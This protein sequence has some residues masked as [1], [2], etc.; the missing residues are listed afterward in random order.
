MSRPSLTSQLIS[1]S[2]GWAIMSKARTLCQ[3]QAILDWGFDIS[4][5]KIL[6]RV[7]ES[8][9]SNPYKV[10]VLFAPED[11]SGNVW[12][13][14]RCSC[15][16]VRDCVHAAAVALMAA[17][18]SE[19]GGSDFTAALA[20]QQAN[21][22][23]ESEGS[24]YP[25][26][27]A[28]WLNRLDASLAGTDA[29][30]ESEEN[31]I[32]MLGFDPRSNEN[33]LQVEPRVARRL[34]NGNFGSNRPH[35][36]RQLAGSQARFMLESDQA[37]AKL[38]TA[39]S[40]QDSQI[41]PGRPVPPSNDGEVLD[42]L[43]VRIVSTGRAYFGDKLDLPLKLGL[44]KDGRVEWV[45][46]EDSRQSPRVVLEQTSSAI[47]I[48]QSSSPWYLDTATGEVGPIRFAYG[49]E[50]FQ[51]L[52]AAPRLA[53][54][55][56]LL[57]HK[58]LSEKA[59]GLPLPQLDITEV[60]RSDQPIVR[61]NLKYE[62]FK[63]PR[64]V[65]DGSKE[66]AIDGDNTATLVFD[67][68]FDASKLAD[69][70]ESYR[71][72]NG[73][74]FI[75]SRR[76]FHFE[77]AVEAKLTDLS[78]KQF[79]SNK[80]PPTQSCWTA[81]IYG[82]ET[83]LKFVQESV[84]LL[85]EDGWQIEADQ[86]FQYQVVDVDSD[87]LVD[88]DE[89]SPF[90]F[91]LDLGIVVDHVRVPL[92][93]IITEAI[94]SSNAGMNLSVSSMDKLNVGGKFYA[95]LPDKRMVALPFERVKDMLSCLTELLD[96][97]N[98][99]EDGSLNISI[100]QVTALAAVNQSES[101][102][103]QGAQSVRSMAAE[104]SKF[105]ILRQ[106]NEPQSLHAVLRPYQ[107][108]G[109]GWL[110]F[111]STF[112]LG[113]ILADDMGLGK[114]VQTLAH[115]AREKEHGKLEGRPCLVVC[116][117]S[118]LPNWLAEIQRLTPSL[119]VVALHGAQRATRFDLVQSADI[120]LSTYPLLVRDGEFLSSIKWHAV[121]L[122][123]A[124]AIKNSHTRA[125][126]AVLQLNSKYRFCLT[127][128]PIENH[129]GELWSQ[130]NFLMPG[131]LGSKVTFDRTFRDPIEKDNNAEQL[132]L[133]LSRVKPF[134]LRRT[135]SQVAPDLPP[136]TEMVK[137]VELEGRQRDL[138]ETVRLSMHKQVL[139]EVKK[140]GLA[141]CGLIILDALLKLRQ[142]CCHPSLVKLAAAAGIGDSAK[143]SYLMGMLDELV[144][145]KR[146]ILIFSQF[147]S[148]LD[149]IVPELS[150]RGI[151]FVE[152]RGDTKDR[153][154]PVERFQKGEVSVFLISLKAGG[155]GLNLTAADTVIHFD[156]WWNP[157]VEDQATARAHRIGQDK[158]VFVYR[159]IAAGTIEERMME[160]QQEKRAV[161]ESILGSDAAG[162]SGEYAPL[163]H[164]D[165]ATL[166]ALF[167]PL[168]KAYEV[169]V[170][171]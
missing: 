165:E 89:S 82:Q 135:K 111:I 23:H 34:K 39:C 140:K 18:D 62:K 96:S 112:K 17:G 127:G 120:V 124:Q 58:I 97:A 66:L 108:E 87:W 117:T 9:R 76:D 131:L 141:S 105:D 136:K 113:G 161:A 122:D 139:Q 88:I 95:H 78:F 159:L 101:F 148:M 75:V 60:Q 53:A 115:I 2:F 137:Y 162:S 84:P 64:L 92:L 73:K 42:L 151:A 158:P 126:Q 149:L 35:N 54:N 40:P 129:L 49:R 15:P 107:R 70:W 28:F 171:C 104:M 8:G 71:W 99:S 12:L 74:H 50:T 121:I 37:I 166:E 110:D 38:W 100:P 13:T 31:V 77:K 44:A 114:T 103:W 80:L 47:K 128:T 130:F 46:Q 55:D 116:P 167:A 146:Q 21:T 156:P 48:L 61:L 123:E 90:W 33:D 25:Q 153:A 154:T 164:L 109:L 59:Q 143:L 138:Y 6:G 152:L 4:G 93:P 150:A 169:E 27:A 45:V 81:R 20:P 7:Q 119:T 30:G 168:A 160:L 51:A 79:K 24:I 125:A 98:L 32:Y 57:I 163:R 16:L 91:S 56:A 26:F 133:L 106:V 3:K 83:W 1:N 142:A 68:G 85:K 69:T 65:H 86:S 19:H 22:D 155:T 67:Y 145:E 10:E 11:E 36:W 102:N 52:M 118:V 147:T 157:A 5:T 29:K 144:E 41:S 63:N 43:L 170:M 14:G 72:S 132:Q 94:R 134:L